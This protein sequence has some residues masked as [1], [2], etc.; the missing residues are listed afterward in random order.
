MKFY[1]APSKTLLQL[2]I[3]HFGISLEVIMEVVYKSERTKVLC[4]MN[5]PV[6]ITQ[7]RLS[8]FLDENSPTAYS[9]SFGIDT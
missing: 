9:L 8:S 1:V 3:I 2:N 4:E 5:L 6:V 7:M